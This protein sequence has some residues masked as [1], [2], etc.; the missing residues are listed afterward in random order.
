MS[1]DEEKML[2]RL[3]EKLGSPKKIDERAEL[4]RIFGKKEKSKE[5]IM[6][7]KM[8]R[9][10]LSAGDIIDLHITQLAFGGQ[11]MGKHIE[12]PVFV[13]D[14]VP[15][16][17]VRV[18]ITKAAK[19]HFFGEISERITGSSDRVPPRCQHVE[20]CGGCQLQCLAYTAQL[21]VKHTMVSDVLKKIGNLDIKLRNVIPSPDTYGYRLRARFKLG[22]EGDKI[23]IGFFSRRSNTLVPIT[24]CHILSPVLN[25]VHKLLPDLLPVPGTAPLPTDITL[26]VGTDNDCVVIHLNSKQPL[27]Y[28]EELLNRCHERNLPVTGISNRS[29]GGFSS[30]GDAIVRHRVGSHVFQVAGHGF[31]QVNRFLLRS[32][33]DQVRMLASPSVDDH[34]LDIYSGVGF[35]SIPMAQFAQSVTGVDSDRDAINF[36]E[37]NAVTA[38]TKNAIFHVG[39]D[40]DC[41]HLDAVREGEFNLMLVDPPRAGLHQNVLNEIIRR[42]PAKLLYVSCDPATLARDL[43]KLAAADFRIRVVQPLD[44]FPHTYHI[45]NL[46]YMTHRYTG[47]QAATEAFVNLN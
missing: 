43:K 31:F 41:F 37:N 22:V 46:V 30:V 33:L 17:T 39:R 13:S 28:I 35:L 15:G 12:K 26:H 25:D 29:N 38:G 9:P 42:K 34:I 1:F 10:I 36:A 14:C 4:E 40:Q 24:Q 8:A 16:D 19:D 23:R 45:E 18:R 32:L 20:S 47:T 11:G 21:K 7:E 3:R 44:L 6:M 5:E 2:E 27:L